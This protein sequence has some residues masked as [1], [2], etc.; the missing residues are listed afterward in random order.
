MTF[1]QKFLALITATVLAVGFAWYMS[2]FEQ[3]K[4]AAPAVYNADG[5]MAVAICM[6]LQSGAM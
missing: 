4:R 2:P 1:M 3:C 5:D 6:R